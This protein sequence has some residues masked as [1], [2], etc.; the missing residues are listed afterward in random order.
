[1]NP[2]CEHKPFTTEVPEIRVDGADQDWV[3][4]NNN[5]YK[6]IKVSYGVTKFEA[7]VICRDN[8]GD[9]FSSSPVSCLVVIIL[10][11]QVSWL[12]SRMRRPGW[13]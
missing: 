6:F 5:L 7:Q 4:I 9:C 12:R 8:G 2:L 1:M 11:W 10:T 13:L 3:T